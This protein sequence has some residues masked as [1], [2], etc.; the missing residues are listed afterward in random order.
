MK[1]KLISTLLAAAMVMAPM[2]VNAEDAT[3]ATTEATTEAATEAAEAATEAGTEA[4]EEKALPTIDPDK[5]C[6]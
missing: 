1:K 5:K 2:A 6:I 3:E 4:A